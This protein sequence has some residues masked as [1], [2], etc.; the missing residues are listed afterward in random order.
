ML[1]ET[2]QKGFQNVSN[3]IESLGMIICWIL[4]HLI[5][6]RFYININI[7]TVFQL[8]FEGFT[9]QMLTSLI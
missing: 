3:F 5:A 7:C 6:K 1:C 8:N 9:M 4:M 2:K